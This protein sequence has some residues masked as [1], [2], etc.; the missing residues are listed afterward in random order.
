[1]IVPDWPAS[2]RVRALATTRQMAGASR[3]PYQRCNLGARSGDAPAIVRGNRDRLVAVADLP[4]APLWLQ[5]MHGCDVLSVFAP[6]PP[7]VSFED[8]PRVDAA[9][10]ANPGIVLA[11][12][13]ADCLPVLFASDDGGVIGAAHAGWRGLSAGVLENTVAAMAV[14]PTRLLAWLGPAIGPQRYEVGDEV[15][16]A[17]VEAE[18]GAAACF[19]ASAAG[20]WR[21]D[22][23]S[24]ARRRLRA[25]GIERIHGGDRCTH[26]EVDSFYSYRRDGA[27]SGRQAAL[28]WIAEADGSMQ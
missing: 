27:A 25:A 28:I 10:T 2:S 21:C 17:F 18:P 6:R 4:S 14:A 5:Q 13:S 7:A 26:T 1:M 9:V 8:E 20:R 19:Q 12:L 22:L 24:L 3:P 16:R 15:R 11:V 23:Y